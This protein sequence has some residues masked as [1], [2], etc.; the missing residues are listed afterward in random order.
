MSQ[1]QIR[2]IVRDTIL[3]N[4]TVVDETAIDT[5]G[6]LVNAY[7]HGVAAAGALI[8]SMLYSGVEGLSILT[9]Q[10][11]ALIALGGGNYRIFIQEASPS[12]VE[13]TFT[14]TDTSALVTIPAG[15]EVSTE[16]GV[17]FATDYEVSMQV[18]AASVTVEATSVTAGLGQNVAAGAISQVS[19][20]AQPDLTVT[21]VAAAAGGAEREDLEHYRLRLIEAWQATAGSLAGIEQGA[22]TVPGI[23]S[24]K[25]FDRLGINGNP[26]GVVKLLVSDREGN[27][28]ATLANAV[29]A[30]MPQYRGAGIP[31][32]VVAATPTYEQISVV[33]TWREGMATTANRELVKNRLVLMTEL[34]QP[35]SANSVAT[36]NADSKLTHARI[37]D[38]CFKVDG[39]EDIQVLLP[40]GTVVPDP[41]A[42]IRSRDSDIAVA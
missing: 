11:D 9:A 10:G 18:G 13:L 24:A 12:R 29:E 30:V 14:R 6:T 36:A 37:H 33:I 19:L 25:A 42:T 27:G 26:A 34:L 39:V 3:A 23:Y 16:G 4:S 31:V 15:Q 17:T 40:V 8:L 7:T 5:D 38:A 35:N 32:E 20:A 28:N 2:Q 21:N 41:G 1:E 22:L